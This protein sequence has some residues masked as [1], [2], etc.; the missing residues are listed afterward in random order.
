MRFEVVHLADGAAGKFL[1]LAMGLPICQIL[2]VQ[3]VKEAVSHLVGNILVFLL[4]VIDFDGLPESI[5][6]DAA[7]LTTAHM[8]FNFTAQSFIQVAIDII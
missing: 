5:H 7:I 4:I 1:R 3:A 2:E 6:D 8:A